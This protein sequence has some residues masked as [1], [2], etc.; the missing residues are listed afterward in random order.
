MSVTSS[1]NGQVSP[2]ASNRRIVN[3]T[4]EGAGPTRRAITRLGIPAAIILVT[5]RTRRIASLSIGFGVAPSQSRKTGPY[6]SQK[7]PRHPGLVGEIILNDR[8][9]HSGMATSSGKPPAMV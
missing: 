8:R 6:G 1:G 2:A 4:V 7:K 3:R 5:S 9:D